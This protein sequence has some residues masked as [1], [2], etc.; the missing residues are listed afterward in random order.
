MLIPALSLFGC[1]LDLPLTHL[2]PI[3]RSLEGAEINK[4]LLAL[5]ECIRSLYQE[6]DH[7]PFRGSKLTQVLKDSFLGD[8]KTVMIA[9][10]SPNMLNCEHTLN[11][12]RYA[13]RY[14]FLA[15]T[16]F[17]LD[18]QEN[19]C[20][21]VCIECLESTF[22]CLCCSSGLCAR[23][24]CAFE[25]LCACVRVG[26]LSLSSHP[27]SFLR[28]KEIRRVDEDD[29]V[30]STSEPAA[31]SS[32]LP[33]PP[34]SSANGGKKQSR[35]YSAAPAG[36]RNSVGGGGGGEVTEEKKRDPGTRV[37]RYGLSNG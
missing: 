25:P 7:T 30:T 29:E 17:P 1:Y 23:N 10:I 34:A 37:T 27:H 28:V 11:T 24:V 13:Y 15:R 31:P 14:V 4:S 8:S 36:G 9:T 26:N 19:S 22:A 2:H 32:P 21:L 18:L 33:P 12:L 6:A 16:R 3:P 35:S 20:L 5:K